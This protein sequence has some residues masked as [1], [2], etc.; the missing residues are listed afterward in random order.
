[1]R[2]TNELQQLGGWAQRETESPEEQ[3]HAMA[4]R[5]KPSLSSILLQWVALLTGEDSTSS[6][7]TRFRCS[8]APDIHVSSA[9]PSCQL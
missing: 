7:G 5:G 9:F 6:A 3:G 8:V 4:N 1:M 2:R